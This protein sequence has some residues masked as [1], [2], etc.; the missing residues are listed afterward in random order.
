MV[1]FQTARELY[2]QQMESDDMTWKK[3]R[4]KA[5]QMYHVN[6]DGKFSD[7][8][9]EEE[10]SLAQQIKRQAMIMSGI[11]P[12]TSDRPT[13]KTKKATKSQESI[14]VFYG[15]EL[16]SEARNAK[17]SNCE[18]SQDLQKRKLLQRKANLCLW[19]NRK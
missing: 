10:E 5:G 7:S 12:S 2:Q 4:S 1:V 6:A 13:V 8:G 17:Q 15:N 11:T 18:Q 9:E 16:K 3:T 14:G 19:K